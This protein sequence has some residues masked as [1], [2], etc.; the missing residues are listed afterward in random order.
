M[1][2]TPWPDGRAPVLL[3]AHAVELLGE[4]ARALLDYLHR[5]PGPDVPEIAAH[6]LATRRTRR[7]R[8]VI[9]AGDRA[10]L[11]AA[12]T[13]LETGGDHPLL[14]RPDPLGAARIAFV[15]P[16]QGT[17]WPG[18][19]E[20]AYRLPRYRSSAQRCA[21]AF[22][23]AGLP[24]PLTY[25]TTA[26]DPDQFGEIE[27]E[28][29][30]FVH[31]VALAD[32]WRGCGVVPDL[33]V[34]HSLGEV[35][36]SHIAG[37]IT[38]PDA[39]AVIAARAA[40]VDRF[41]G[42]YAVAA[43]GIGAD[44]AAELIAATDGWLELSVIN[45]PNSVAVSGDREAVRAA[46]RAV[47]SGGGFARE[48]TVNFPV[49]TSILE[50]LRAEFTAALP[51]A[52]FAET[53]VRFIGGTTGEEVAAGTTFDGYWYRNLRDPVRFD[54]AAATALRHGATVFVELSAH[55]ALLHPLAEI[56]EDP[57]RPGT[58]EVL[59]VGSGRRDR[60][61][62]EQLSAGLAAVAAAD[63]G[64]P[65]ADLRGG[66]G[67]AA[68]P[69]RGFPPAPM[70]TTHLWA[71]RDPLP[72]P[73][74]VVVAV[75]DWQPHPGAA[76]PGVPSRAVAILDL[77]AGDRLAHAVEQA[78]HAHPGA[79]AV[80]PDRADTLI[81]IAPELA[82]TDPARAAADLA[83]GA[84][85]GLLGYTDRLGPRCRDVW[86]LTTGAERVRAADPVP[87]PGAAA[88]AAAHRSL[89]FDHPDQ[90]FHHLDLVPGFDTHPFGPAAVVDTVLT[91]TGEVALR[92]D[93][94]APRRYRR[95]LLR[96]NDEP[97]ARQPD[98]DLLD[99]V[100]ITGGTGAVGLHYA[101]ALA[102]RGARR[103]VLL[104]RRG[105]DPAELAALNATG[106]TEVVAP[107]CD[108]TDPDAL[109]AVA[110]E[111]GGDGASLV[112]HA[113][114]AAT[115]GAGRAGAQ[116]AEAVTR[117]V[118]EA[119]AA[120][121]DGLVHLDAVWPRRPHAP[122]L[123]CS[124]VIGVWGGQGAAAYAA[125]NRLLDV[126][127]AQLRQRGRACT[128]IRWGLWPGTDGRTGILDAAETARVQRAGLR[129]MDPVRAVEIS[130]RAHSGDPLV[131]AA[132][133][134][135]LRRLGVTLTADPDTEPELIPGPEPARDE[136]GVPGGTDQA[137]VPG[138]TDQTGVPG[139][140]DQTGVPDGTDPAG[141]VRAELAAVLDLPD[142][143]DLD[144]AAPLFD[145]G[146]DSL[147]AV[148]LR[149]RFTRAVGATVPLARL[150][151]GITG[152][153]LVADLDAACAT[154][155]LPDSTKKV[156]F[157]RD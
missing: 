18:M 76:P 30:Q 52:E 86:L 24:S 59:A 60:A 130:L 32:V 21:E 19:G 13:A 119:C 133:T 102:Q 157:S 154:A 75:E 26:A 41:A 74:T 6:L 47:R 16:G 153:E 57:T 124:S 109:A 65:W 122:I 7:H 67:P 105:L 138:G 11:R 152:T 129:P 20:Q 66:A 100:V 78:V 58:R 144:L 82:E 148:D 150:L 27:V 128:A 64:Y 127:A 134:D 42:H 9:R 51:R 15:F 8:A 111:H 94:G 12:L 50:P 79:D 43:L 112:V 92:A 116:S 156:E 141:V 37:A 5:N 71:R 151:G 101:R 85:A 35:A 83:A 97:P 14:S 63:P 68:P 136:A 84:A 33:T 131:L 110:A 81:V 72:A 36:A 104:S 38:L 55:P 98:A 123:L 73:P 40:V 146:I 120:K 77:S 137:G 113:A 121:V 142:P 23:A 149:K 44:A 69:L 56:C 108:L 49:H 135:R 155:A 143:A 93:A 29:A 125:A 126:V 140:T 39:V 62:S 22:T 147:L 132:D 114:G 96:R 80:A 17:Q 106:N 31:A 87:R 54:H 117:A 53:A 3:S 61:L 10:D 89:G 95:R 91:E 1:T 48:I 107:P 2:L 103:I 145:L 25:L 118:S 70:R 115:F 90:E 4:D 88:L 28:G 45:A 139:G 46:V 99:D 34:G